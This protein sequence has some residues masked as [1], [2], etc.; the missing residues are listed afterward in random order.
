MSIFDAFSPRKRKFKAALTLILAEYTYSQLWDER[1]QE[2]DEA[3]IQV[4]AASGTE[5][6][7]LAYYAMPKEYRYGLIAAALKQ[8]R[9]PPAVE[10]EEWSLSGNPFSVNFED[11]DFNKAVEDAIAYLQDKGVKLYP[12]ENEP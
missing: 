12:E 8:L 4:V 1:R 2:V 3:C 11:P 7:I 6:P 5:A 9:I 10:G